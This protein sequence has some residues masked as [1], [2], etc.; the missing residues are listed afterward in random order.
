MIMNLMRIFRMYCLICRFSCR[1]KMRKV[2]LCVLLGYMYIASC[3]HS[4]HG[5][6]GGMLYPRESESRQ[7]QEMN[8]MWNFRADMS[9]TRDAGM[10]EGWFKQKLSQVKMNL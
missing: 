8:G 10:T 9:P 4:S 3:M 6:E 1:M 2:G 5:L 7:I